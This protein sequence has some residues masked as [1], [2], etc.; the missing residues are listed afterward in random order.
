MLRVCCTS[1]RAC[2]PGGKTTSAEIIRPRKTAA[3]RARRTRLF[4]EAKRLF[5]IEAKSPKTYLIGV[6]DGQF[7]L[8]RLDCRNVRRNA[9]ASSLSQFLRKQEPGALLINP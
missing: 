3:Q 1:S 9:R 4:A 8:L 7:L 5:N 2:E 6:N